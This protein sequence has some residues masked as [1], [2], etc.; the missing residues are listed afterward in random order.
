MK[1]VLLAVLSAVLAV[2]LVAAPAHAS[3][4]VPAGCRVIQGYSDVT[5]DNI[6]YYETALGQRFGI[7]HEF[8]YLTDEPASDWIGAVIAHGAT[9][10]ITVEPDSPVG[11]PLHT[12]PAGVYDR[13]IDAWADTFRA[14]G[15]PLYFRFAHE[16]QGY[17]YP[18]GDVGDNTPADYVR[19]FRYVHDRVQARAPNVIFAWTPYRDGGFGYP[20]PEYYP[21]DAYVDWMG[22]SAYNWGTSGGGDGWEAID[23]IV[24]NTYGV[25]RS[26]NPNKPIMLAEWASSEYGGDKA[27]WIAEAPLK[28]VTM[29]PAIR[30]VVWFGHGTDW[31][32]DSSAAALAASRVAFGPSSPL[33]G[34]SGAA[35]PPGRGGVSPGGLPAPPAGDAPGAVQQP[36]PG[37]VVPGAGPALGPL[38]ASATYAPAPP[39]ELRGREA[40][41]VYRPEKTVRRSA[42]LAASLLKAP[43]YLP[44]VLLITTLMLAIGGAGMVLWLGARWR[45]RRS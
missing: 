31:M 28:I 37:V 29:F 25:L 16:M 42:S 40:T 39:A 24:G 14:A 12:I 45:R 32:L 20:I 9:P 10:M 3:V 7:F 35:Q 43:G 8:Y 26:I 6:L 36:A 30:A 41:A 19:T 2:P 44:S 33:C 15:V 17:W 11:D 4:I 13:E 5:L 1:R 38:D 22:F 34:G 23:E 27:A 21:G 18:W